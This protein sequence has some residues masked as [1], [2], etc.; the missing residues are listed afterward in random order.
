V[1][2]TA[3]IVAVVAFPGP[4]SAHTELIGTTPAEG[5]RLPRAP[6]EVVVRYSAPLAG[7]VDTQVELD[8]ADVAG[9][10]PRLA[11]RDAGRLIIPIDA[12]DHG[13]RLVVRWVVRSPD[14]HLLEGDLSVQVRPKMVG[15]LR[16]VG[17]LLRL[18]AADLGVV[19]APAPAD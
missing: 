9:G 18:A 4:A 8:G 7:I 17:R 10:I 3:C 16:R 2:A 14:A 13:G 5:A 12:G 1:L 11:R 6:S 15:A 19:A